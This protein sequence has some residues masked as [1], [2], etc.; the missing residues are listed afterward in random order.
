SAARQFD[1]SESTLRG[2]LK[3]AKPKKE[4]H[5]SQQLLSQGQKHILAQWCKFLG[6]Q[7]E[8]L[9]KKGIKQKVYDMTGKV[10][11]D[12]WLK[13]FL[14]EFP[15]IRGFKAK[16][17]DPKRAAAFNT[18]SVHDFFDKLEAVIKA[19]QIPCTNIYN[20]DEKGIQLGGGRKNSSTL[21]FFDRE[22]KSRYI[23]KS[24]SLVMVTVIEAACADG[25]MVPPGFIL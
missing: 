2:R 5:A 19:H 16:G 22:D 12:K 25:T 11:S 13:K 15:T 21:Y 14:N 20:M 1:V 23:L 7:A 17:L 4:A 24:D 18:E 3:G 10:P 8:P 9:S 6:Q